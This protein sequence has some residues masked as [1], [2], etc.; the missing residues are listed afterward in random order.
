MAA[1]AKLGH[2][3]FTL[4]R[5]LG[6]GAVGAAW[7]AR[8]DQ[9]NGEVALKLLVPA[10]AH[11]PAAVEDLRRETIKSRKLC[12]PNIVRTY[13]LLQHETEPAFIVLEFVDGVPLNVFKD[14]QANQTIRWDYLERLVRQICSALAHA[15]DAKIV[16]R[17]I[18]PANLILN[19]RGQV[20]L[21]DFGIAATAAN[22]L[23]HVTTNMGNTGTPIYMSPQQ[24][25]GRPPR[26]ADDIY[27]LGATLYELLVS[28]P[29]F[30]FA[31]GL[32]ND[33]G[34][35]AKVRTMPAKPIE[36]RQSE[37]GITNPVPRHVATAIMACLAKEPAARPASVKA[38]AATLGLGELE[39]AAV[40]ASPA[41]TAVPV[42]LPGPSD[43]QRGLWTGLAGVAFL[44]ALVLLIT[45]LL[46]SK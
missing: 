25:E 2:G 45:K 39:A 27:S 26:P 15:H 14:G 38:F 9:L 42:A 31:D 36:Q 19:T 29:P 5:P 44:G 20:K 33:G 41:E 7:L 6:S 8:D 16:H 37:L 11:D 46:A 28:Q 24:M 32:P 23:G 17:D 18:K 22:T 3:R 10:L 30:H 4:V 1:G 34:I 21:A 40:S 43:L 13:E 12:H 35:A